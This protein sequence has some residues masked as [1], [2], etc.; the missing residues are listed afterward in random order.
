MQVSIFFWIKKENTQQRIEGSVLK[1]RRS[2]VST[3]GIGGR[4]SLAKRNRNQKSEVRIL[5]FGG[6]FYKYALETRYAH[7]LTHVPLA[8]HPP[9]SLGPPALFSCFACST[10]LASRSRLLKGSSKKKKKKRITVESY[11]AKFRRT[12]IFF[13]NMFFHFSTL[14]N[15]F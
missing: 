1:G 2:W 14:F 11:I 8:H 5:E 7:K 15:S 12:K 6:L 3:S 4:R 13:H 9:P 10:S